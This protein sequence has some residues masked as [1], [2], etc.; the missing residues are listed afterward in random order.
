MNYDFV[1]SVCNESMIVEAPIGADLLSPSC[2]ECKTLMVQRY[3]A[4][5][6]VLKGKG[7]YKTDKG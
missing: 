7:F 2:S 5:N 3:S 6:I 1:C 4:P